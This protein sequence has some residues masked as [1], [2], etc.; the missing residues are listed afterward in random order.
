MPSFW[1]PTLS[2]LKEKI[3]SELRGFAHFSFSFVLNE[4]SLCSLD[5]LDFT[6]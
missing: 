6:E 4:V 5:W 3:D 1:A 2:F